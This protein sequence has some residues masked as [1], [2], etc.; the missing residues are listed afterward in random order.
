MRNSYS[1]VKAEGIVQVEERSALHFSMSIYYLRTSLVKRERGRGGRG[2]AKM[3]K[4]R[5]RWMYQTAAPCWAGNGKAAGTNMNISADRYSSLYPSLP[6]SLSQSVSHLFCLSTSLPLNPP[7]PPPPTPLLLS[8]YSLVEWT[9]I[10]KGVLEMERVRLREKRDLPGLHS[11]YQK[12]APEY[13]SGKAVAAESCF[14]LAASPTPLL[15]TC[16]GLA[17]GS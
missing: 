16:D 8:L 15:D 13:K 6:L 17:W 10:M 3:E 11:G 7:P 12:M 5:E 1:S 9:V 2:R 4:E 14:N